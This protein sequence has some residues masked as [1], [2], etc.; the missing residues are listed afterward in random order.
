MKTL[1]PLFILLLF[2]AC[3]TPRQFRSLG[4]P[5]QQTI[6]YANSI[7]DASF[8]KESEIFDELVALS[9][10]NNN[11]MWKEINGKQHVL[12]ATWKSATIASYWKLG[13]EGLYNTGR[14]ENWVTI[15]PQLSQKLDQ[16]KFKK[17][18]EVERRLEQM[19]GLPPNN[20][21][22]VFIEMWVKPSDLFRPCPDKEVTDGAC[23]VCFPNATDSTHIAWINNLRVNS[24]YTNPENCDQNRYPWTQLGYTYDWNPYNKTHVGL[25][26]FVIQPGADIYVTRK[27]STHIYLELEKRGIHVKQ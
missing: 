8:P 16:F 23:G 14:F 6:Y 18:S 10:N 25:S 11:L 13:E 3:S 24:F 9:P 26:E 19:L 4:K 27:D 12:A 7:E 20:G 22:E 1:F 17:Q 2:I 21:K 15:V 5:D